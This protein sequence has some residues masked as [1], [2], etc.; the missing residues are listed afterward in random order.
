MNSLKKFLKELK[1]VRWPSSKE[2]NKIFATILIFV[3]IASLILFGLA[4]G[5]TTLWNEWG[6]GLNGK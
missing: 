2:G 6:V 3:S 4:I 1:R 5:L